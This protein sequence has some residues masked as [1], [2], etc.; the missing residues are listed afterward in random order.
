M[1]WGALSSMF[2]PIPCSENESM[3]PVEF[4]SPISLLTLTL[5]PC[6]LPSERMLLMVMFPGEVRVTFPAMPSVENVF[7][8]CWA[9]M[10]FWLRLSMVMSPPRCVPWERMFSMLTEPS[11]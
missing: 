6:S 11:A 2:P 1:F 9:L 8:A 7:N 10:L 3:F 5:P 4:I